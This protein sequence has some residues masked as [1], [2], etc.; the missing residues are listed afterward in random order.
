MPKF[1]LTL[2]YDG[3]PFCG[4]QRQGETQPL[5][6]VQQTL[7]DAI[8]KFSGET[9]N[10]QV[11]GRTDAGVHALAQVAHVDLAREISPGEIQGALNFHVKPHPVAVLKVESVGDDFHARMSAKARHYTYRIINRRAPLALD[12]NRA[13]HV[14]IQLDETAMQAAANHLLGHHDFTSFRAAD[15][16][17]KSPLKTLDRFDIVR[18]GDDIDCHVSARSFLHHQVR[19]MVGTIALAGRG[20]WQPDDVKKALDACDRSAA[21]PTAPPDGLFFIRVDY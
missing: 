16:Q 4:W 11:A 8:L 20:K 13:W 19:N 15:C 12:H 21:G 3:S 2:E 6:S 5:P 17:A 7:E 9:V 1:K 14:P 10:L 18:H